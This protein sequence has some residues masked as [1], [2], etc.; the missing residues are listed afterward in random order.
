[1]RIGSV[2]LAAPFRAQAARRFATEATLHACT[3]CSQAARPPVR[4]DLLLLC[5]SGIALGARLEPFVEEL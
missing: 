2:E 1:M 3:S 5:P 4:G